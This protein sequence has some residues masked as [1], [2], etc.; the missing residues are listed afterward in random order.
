MVWLSIPKNYIKLEII[1][2]AMIY[3]IL[4]QISNKL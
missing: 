1:L 2:K 3:I 4:F